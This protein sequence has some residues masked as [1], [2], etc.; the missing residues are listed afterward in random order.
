MLGKTN[1]I[2]CT[3]YPLP[4]FPAVVINENTPTEAEVSGLSVRGSTEPF[5]GWSSPLP[6]I[7]SVDVLTLRA[8]VV[9]Y[10]VRSQLRHGLS[11]R[12]AECL[13]LNVSVRGNAGSEKRGSWLGTHAMKVFRSSWIRVAMVAVCRRWSMNAFASSISLKRFRCRRAC[14]SLHPACCSASPNRVMSPKR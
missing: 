1:E 3:P 2:F 7:L 4:L 13:Q 14:R 6:A 10:D 8:K 12:L 11:C 9:G 5:T